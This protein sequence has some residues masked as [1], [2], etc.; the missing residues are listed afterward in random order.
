MSLHFA[1]GNGAEYFFFQRRGRAVV[2]ALGD[3]DRVAL[4]FDHDG[5]VFGGPAMAAFERRWGVVAVVRRLL[6]RL[7]RIACLGHLLVAKV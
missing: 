7:F 6:L 5:A 3:E 1:A 2:E 4:F